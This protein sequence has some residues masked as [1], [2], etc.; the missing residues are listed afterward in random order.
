MDLSH[1][2]IDEARSAVAE[3]KTSATALAELFYAKIE[4][5]DPKFDAQ[6]T[7]E[8]LKSVG[9]GTVEVVIG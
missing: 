7:S 6:V 4:A 9:A 8:H 2:T 5:D 1:L 3:G